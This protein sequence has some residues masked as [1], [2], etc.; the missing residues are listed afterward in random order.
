M[1]EAAATRFSC[2]A[3][4]PD[5][6][7]DDVIAQIV[8][9]ARRT[10]SWSNTQPWE[11]VVTRPDKTRALAEVLS[12]LAR[13]QTPAAPDVEFPPGF[14]GVYLERRREVGFGLY[15]ALGIARE[16]RA[17]REAQHLENFH[18][19]GAPHVA[20]LTMPTGM[21]VYGGL[22]LGGFLATF[23]LAAESA[24]VA[25]IAQAALAAYAKPLRVA[26]GIGPDRAL[27]CGISFGYADA[28]HPAN[29][30]RASRAPREQIFRFA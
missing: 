14:A 19:F 16:D 24:G 18:F 12:N 10:A 30:F 27:L 26:L 7:P 1:C 6:V 20:L 8:D 21:G 22:D 25:T 23:L 9:V 29:R 11:I 3:F 28:A 15:A 13:A 5:P 17:A 2:R 4:L